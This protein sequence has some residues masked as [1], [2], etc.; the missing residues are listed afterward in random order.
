MEKTKIQTDRAPAA[1]GP[2]SQ[3][4]ESGKIIFTAGQ[5][6]LTPDGGDLTKAPVEEQTKQVLENLKGI[7]ESAGSSLGHVLKTT[8]FMTDLND[9][10]SMNKMYSQ[11]FSEPF[12][13]R[14]TVQVAALPKG[15]KIE[16]EAVANK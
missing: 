15:A 3:A 8:V 13:A 4:I 11:Y 16:I 1:I 5:I 6:P 9:F 7:L 12:P 14:S 2:Y 10:S